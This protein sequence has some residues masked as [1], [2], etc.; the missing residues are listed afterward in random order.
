L[1]VAKNDW[2][3]NGYKYANR[4]YDLTE[5]QKKAWIKWINK[6]HPYNWL[7]IPFVGRIPT[8]NCS[9][10]AR[11]TVKKVTGEKLAADGTAGVEEPR[12][13]YDS[14]KE[15]ESKKS[16]KNSAPSGAPK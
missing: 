14:I 7:T 4:Y 6:K 12:I 9:S 5:E 10:F 16:T 3:D 15:A 13:L 8:N 1:R 11:D 2:N